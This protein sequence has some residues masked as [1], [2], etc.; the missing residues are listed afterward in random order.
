MARVFFLFWILFFFPSAC[1]VYSG[2]TAAS[3]SSKVFLIPLPYGP[4][5][6]LR[7]SQPVIFLSGGDFACR[8]APYDG[9][10][11]RQWVERELASEESKKLARGVYNDL[12]G[13]GEEAGEGAAAGEGGAGGEG[14]EGG[15]PAGRSS[16]PVMVS[17]SDNWLRLG[18]SILN[19]NKGTG[20]SFWLVVED[21]TFQAVTSDGRSHSGSLQESCGAPF[22][23]LVPP[24]MNVLWR[25]HSRTSHLE[26]LTLYL[27]GFPIDDRSGELSPDLALQAAAGASQG[28]QSTASQLISSLS[29]GAGGGGGSPANNRPAIG[30]GP[31]SIPRY[32]VELTLRGYFMDT[33]GLRVASYAGRTRFSTI[34]SFR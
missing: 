32:T 23:Y 12:F 6:A 5:D 3:L 21:M 11:V 14:G 10:A 20:G 2:P 26:N 9:R 34:S 7:P 22:L 30:Q 18:L 17:V 28:G 8:P 25:P 33:N 4:K 24:G 15:G 31:I 27:S 16:E 1:N 13:G 19:A 29:E